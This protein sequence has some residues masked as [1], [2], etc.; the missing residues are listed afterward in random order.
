[1]RVLEN[2]Y[3]MDWFNEHVLAAGA[4]LLGIGLWK[5]GDVALIDGALVNGSA[6]AVGGVAGVAAPA[7]DRPPV[8]VCAGHAA[9]H[10]RPDDLAAVAVFSGL[11]CMLM[12][13]PTCKK[14]NE[15]TRW[16]C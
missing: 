8:L 6:R 9:G 14:N 11:R 2:K 4:R 12:P 15:G 1:M 13:A 3:Y 16:V 10:L 5:G 7:A